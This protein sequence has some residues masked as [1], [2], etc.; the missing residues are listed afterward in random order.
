MPGSLASW[1]LRLGQAIARY[2]L[3]LFFLAFGALK[4]TAGEAAAIHPLLAHS[5]ILGWLP[6]IADLRT[7][8]AVIGVV[9]IILALLV[10]AR[11]LRPRASAVGSAGMALALVVTLS[12]LV[13]TPHLD[14]ALASFIVKD[15]TLLGVAIWSAG[16]AWEAAA[17]RSATRGA[18][19]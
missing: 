17:D 8:S 18:A 11:P 14:P 19:A 12:F 9:E 4:F 1:T 10:A 5:P 6:M 2:S 3:V 15:L 16:E 13:T 7:A